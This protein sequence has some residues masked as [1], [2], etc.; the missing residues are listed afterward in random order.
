[1]F[2]NS[3]L[4]LLSLENLANFAVLAAG[5]NQALGQRAESSRR[6]P[7]WRSSGNHRRGGERIERETPSGSQDELGHC[8]DRGV[9]LV[10]CNF[11]LRS[12]RRSDQHPVA[13]S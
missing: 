3:H 7:W 12:G 8:S 6:S 2:I 10:D 4:G 13:T 9:G 11:V 1:M 5:L